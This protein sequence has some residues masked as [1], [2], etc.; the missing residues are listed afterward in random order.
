[1]VGSSG[2][3]REKVGWVVVGGDSGGGLCGVWLV[4][5]GV[6]LCGRASGGGWCGG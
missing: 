3:L 6:V 4:L 1:V 2:G 5:W